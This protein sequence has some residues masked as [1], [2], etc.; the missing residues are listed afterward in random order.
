MWTR[1]V[2]LLSVATQLRRSEL[3]R[4][5][6]IA[7]AN[8]LILS[9]LYLLKP[10][11]NALF[12]SHL[13]AGQLPWVLLLAALV[14]GITALP[15]G[16]AIERTSVRRLVATSLPFFALNLIAFR[17]VLD[18]ASHVV[19]FAFY[20]WVNLYGHFVTSLLWLLAGTVFDVREARRVFGVIG[21]AGI[22]GAVVGGALAQLALRVGTNNLLWI[23]VAE[24]ALC[25]WALYRGVGPKSS[26]P[27]EVASGRRETVLDDFKQRPLFRALVFMG[28]FAAIVPTLA[29]IQFNYVIDRVF[30]GSDEKTAF[31]G[32]F[33]ALLNVGAF[34]LQMFFTP[35]ILSRFG[36]LVALLTLPIALS[37]GSALLLVMPAL[38]TATLLKASD[39]GLRHSLNKS[40][41]ELLFVPLP[42]R[43]RKRTKLFLDA[44][45]DNF[46]AGIGAILA[47]LVTGSL[48]LGYLT[49]SWISLGAALLWGGYALLARRAYVQTFRDALSRREIDP[50]E[51]RV[52]LGDVHTI[53]HVKSALESGSERQI[54][55][56]LQLLSDIRRDGLAKVIAPLTEHASAEVRA[57]ALHVWTNQGA[58][59][60]LIERAEAL[61]D[62]PDATVSKE[63]VRTLVIGAGKRAEATID[64][65]LNDPE[66]RRRAGA[67]GCLADEFDGLAPRLLT[68]ERIAKLVGDD[69]GGSVAVRLELARALR[70]LP[71]DETSGWLRQLSADP[72][73]RVAALALESLG[74]SGD[75][76]AIEYL[77]SELADRRLRRAA[78]LALARFGERAVSPLVRTYQY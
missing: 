30:S 18:D 75:P 4:V 7:L 3:G 47:L 77:V 57:G 58:E 45:V 21:A 73:P 32:A 61:L 51:L 35:R 19:V 23:V 16:R 65:F 39:A 78:S 54:V 69:R 27:R 11:R 66:T 68:Q 33:F 55:Y 49:L 22:F 60:A 56:A 48:G 31:F 24:L 74:E 2:E 26:G 64:A 53:A 62:D 9:S 70:A 34:V 15:L 59:P 28:V 63:A 76:E 67:L 25:T 29:D 43:V 20:I 52:R 50:G 1:L 13:G 44:T 8:A 38:W 41:L 40:A 5:V 36:L 10:A 12:L 6:P 72:S 37:L 17:F 71:F 42:N 14:G 46:G